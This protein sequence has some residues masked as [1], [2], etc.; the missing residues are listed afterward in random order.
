MNKINSVV[1]KEKANCKRPRF[2]LVKQFAKIRT[3]NLELGVESV[4]QVMA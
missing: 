3:N 4:E 2:K 1:N